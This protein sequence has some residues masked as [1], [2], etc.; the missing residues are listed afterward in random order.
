MVIRLE[1]FDLS[2]K[3][4]DT[5][6]FRRQMAILAKLQKHGPVPAGEI[7]GLFPTRE[8]EG[9]YPPLSPV[10]VAMLTEELTLL[11]YVEAL[12]ADGRMGITTR[13]EEKLA[14]F[15]ES[16]PLEHQQAFAEYT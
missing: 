8:I 13:G 1:A 6:Y 5:P 2:E 10:M 11:G 15:R 12:E 16:L 14:G 3:G 7:L 4:F 9:I